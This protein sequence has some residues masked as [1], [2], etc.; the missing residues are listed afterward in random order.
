MGIT[1]GLSLAAKMVLIASMYFGRLG[2]ITVAMIL[3]KGEKKGRP[4]RRL[5]D[6]K[7][8]I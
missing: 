1:G 4:H 7:I 5:P 2:P 6:G 8:Y 3:N